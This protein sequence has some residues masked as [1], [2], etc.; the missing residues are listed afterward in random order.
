MA[1][2]TQF[3]NGLYHAILA[4]KRGIGSPEQYT[5]FERSFLKDN[6]WHQQTNAWE[7]NSMS[8]KKVRKKAR[9][10]PSMDFTDFDVLTSTPEST[11]GRG[12]RKMAR[13]K[14]LAKLRAYNSSPEK[15][16]NKLNIVLDVDL[17]DIANISP[18]GRSNG[19]IFSGSSKR[20][21]GGSL[22]CSPLNTPGGSL[23]HS[24]G[25][26][27]P[28]GSLGGSLGRS[29]LNTPGRTGATL[30]DPMGKKSRLERPTSALKR[31]KSGARR[32][33]SPGFTRPMPLKMKGMQQKALSVPDLT[34]GSLRRVAT[35]TGS[36]TNGSPP[37]K[38]SPTSLS[39]RS[40]N[41]EILVY[42]LPDA[43]ERPQSASEEED[44]GSDIDPNEELIVLG[45]K[46][47]SDKDKSSLNLEA[48]DLGVLCAKYV[49]KYVQLNFP[50]P[51]CKG[52][53]LSKN[54]LGDDGVLPLLP[55]LHQAGF[56]GVERMDLRSND[57]SPE[58]FERIAAAVS[59]SALKAL[60]LSSCPGFKKNHMGAKGAAALSSMLCEC[61]SLEELRLAGVGGTGFYLLAKAGLQN[62]SDNLH[63]LDFRSNWIPDK[64]FT[65][66]CSV[67]VNTNVSNLMLNRNPF[68]E[69]GG[70][71]L[72]KLIE[73]AKLTLLDISSCEISLRG[74]HAQ[75]HFYRNLHNALI[76]SQTLRTLILDD[77]QIGSEGAKNLRKALG[78]KPT[79]S[80]RSLSIA[81]C[82]LGASEMQQIALGLSEN[83]KL[84]RINLR[85]NVI[86][87]E[88][89]IAVAK[90][91]QRGPED[92]PCALMHVN[93]SLTGISD[94][95][96]SPYFID[97]MDGC[98]KLLSLDFED[99]DITAISGEQVINHVE[100][101]LIRSAHMQ[102]K[103]SH[104][105]RLNNSA[106]STMEEVEDSLNQY[107]QLITR[108][109]TLQ[110]LRFAKNRMGKIQLER[111][112]DL[113]IQNHHTQEQRK[114]FLEKIQLTYWHKM[115][116]DPFPVVQDNIYDAAQEY[117]Q[118]MKVLKVKETEMEEFVGK[119]SAR[120]DKME[121][122]LQIIHLD[123][124]TQ[125]NNSVKAQEELKSKK[126]NADRNNKEMMAAIQSRIEKEKRKVERLREQI[127]RFRNDLLDSNNRDEIE[128]D[129]IDSLRKWVKDL[130][131]E[132]AAKADAYQVLI[133]E[134]KGFIDQLE[135]TLK[136][137]K[138][139]L[140]EQ[141]RARR[142]QQHGDDLDSSPPSRRSS[143]PPS[144]HKSKGSPVSRLS[145]KDI[146]S[147]PSGQATPTPK[148][149]K[150]HTPK[151]AHGAIAKGKKS[152]RK[153]KKHTLGEIIALHVDVATS[154]TQLEGAI[155]VQKSHT[156]FSLLF[157]GLA[158]GST[159][160]VSLQDNVASR[161]FIAQWKIFREKLTDD[162]GV[163]NDAAFLPVI[164]VPASIN[165]PQLIKTISA[166]IS[167][168]E[169]AISGLSYH[170]IT[171]HGGKSGHTSSRIS[172]G[173]GEGTHRSGSGDSGD[174]GISTQRSMNLDISEQ[175]TS[176]R[177]G[178][179]LESPTLS[180]RNV[181]DVTPRRGSPKNMTSAA[182]AA[183]T[184]FAKDGIEL[185]QNGTPRS[186]R[187]S[188]PHMPLENLSS[189]GQELRRSP[190]NKPPNK[191][192]WGD[193]GSGSASPSNRLIL[194]ELSPEVKKKRS[195]GR[196]GS[197][198]VGFNRMK[199]RV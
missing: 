108:G 177:F 106:N 6:Q 46:E 167:I 30:G 65:K 18:T 114:L 184:Q 162:K 20:S 171:Q 195:L 2:S 150:S 53:N 173:S 10:P 44:P 107:K 129:K 39:P 147:N 126:S 165:V 176:R 155:K 113:L 186:R 194:D 199:K 37:A 96:F 19:K 90:A 49:G 71:G 50:H 181:G 198:A 38:M 130:M 64:A 25:V 82:G 185:G 41:G 94:P 99:N 161:N 157:H 121:D 168:P 175:T 81:C 47:G 188:L 189:K 21:P 111:I 29:P 78:H 14:S 136:K 145:L 8:K 86:G 80:L 138:K 193:S 58:G 4:D 34:K 110:S 159:I 164:K 3:I 100:R 141:A 112:N 40:V 27:S 182:A 187:G 109:L 85:G 69:Q 1:N 57:L 52:I 104:L 101:I 140:K 183:A 160:W 66:I 169:R 137:K 72:L 73:H 98:N 154:P 13:P 23:G 117:N 16:G 89:S 144:A 17:A 105:L 142:Q 48:K 128:K 68:S 60:D 7:L 93:L 135:G 151:A 56:L 153:N 132:R 149:N 158:E 115:R 178:K 63:T 12:R 179:A 75:P 163:G 180:Y 97:V 67:L 88:G 24:L 118:N 123:S 61:D 26:K 134:V 11:T 192:S 92:P 42:T 32:P 45:K 9:S 102:D 43:D 124:Q 197:A 127:K 51:K 15:N 33:K 36:P 170:D 59:K 77:N 62:A 28:G 191:G 91:M 139:E 31:P 166:T 74:S 190:S 196:P 70:L 119:H 55:L 152:K 54:N 120:T 103:L 83:D 116:S 148:S 174:S 131:T 146:S 5:V 172:R 79:I 76:K 35:P 133:V 95:G 87:N 143:R 156:V 122:E 84:I 22:G 125:W